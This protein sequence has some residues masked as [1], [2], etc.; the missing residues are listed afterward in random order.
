MDIM[1]SRP[2]IIAKIIE[3]LHDDSLIAGPRP[4]PLFLKST[5]YAGIP[6]A[7][8]SPTGGPYEKRRDTESRRENISKS[9]I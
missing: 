3:K 6:T 7:V 4:I 1:G 8:V 9:G 2:A 5:K